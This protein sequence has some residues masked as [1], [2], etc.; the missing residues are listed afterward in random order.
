M[1]D[2]ANIVVLS[3]LPE[4]DI[5]LSTP[6][7]L[8]LKANYPN[9]HIIYWT[10]NDL[11]PLLLSSSPYI[12]ETVEYDPYT[13]MRNKSESIKLF[14]ANILID[15]T[16]SKESQSFV[17]PKNV[18]V[19]TLPKKILSKKH[20]VETY[21]STIMPFCPKLPPKLFPTIYPDF[22]AKSAIAELIPTKDLRTKPFIV[23]A[24]SV[25]KD[26]PSRAWLEDGWTYLLEHLIAERKFTPIIMGSENDA[27]FCRKLIKNNESSAVN[28][29]GKTDLLQSSAIIK[30]SLA[31]IACDSLFAH[32]SVCIGVPV[33][34]LYGP[35][36]PIER[37][38]YGF[39]DLVL[40][41]NSDCRCKD[42]MS[43]QFVL[44]EDPGDCM[45][46]IMLAEVLEKLEI[47]LKTNST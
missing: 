40:N 1:Q 45:H 2:N 7:A 42:Q 24:P 5:F 19:Y 38:P 15:L 9:S 10:Q 47:V 36:N 32:L 22:L 21:L 23:L 33:I 18:K 4:G 8:T 26:Y 11:C 30:A 35:T 43:C 17:I 13:S 14:G 3:P 27:E 25:P 20:V 12:D 28:I 34:G 39:N 41:Q 29:A 37:G 46:R 16:L 44:P 6:V 31:T